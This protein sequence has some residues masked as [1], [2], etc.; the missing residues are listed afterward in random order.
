MIEHESRGGTCRLVFYC[1]MPIFIPLKDCPICRLRELE[2][3]LSLIADSTD[4]AETER[5]ALEALGES[6]NV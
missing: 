2:D 6:R 4:E 1:D 3:A 5:V